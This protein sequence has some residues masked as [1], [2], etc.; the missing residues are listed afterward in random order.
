[1]KKY[2]LTITLVAISLFSFAQEETRLGVKG[3]FNLATINK[4]PNASMRF[5]VNLGGKVNV[6]LK[7]KMSLQPEIYISWQGARSTFDGS[8]SKINLTYLNIPVVYKY[9]F[10]P[11]IMAHAGLQMGA[12]L[13]AKEKDSSG[14]RSIQDDLKTTDFGILL[15]GEYFITE[16]IS[17]ELRFNLGLKNIVDNPNY[18]HKMKNMTFQI[19][20]SYYF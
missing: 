16:D 1:M 10:N 4:L 20:G 2:L 17:A 6:F 15:G 11:K 13:T 14:K 8:K 18:D 19:G 12:L 5:S 3:G 9:I 7:E